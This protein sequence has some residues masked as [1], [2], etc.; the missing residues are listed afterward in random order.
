MRVPRLGDRLLPMRR[1]HLTHRRALIALIVLAALVAVASA[2][3]VLRV[4][5]ARAEA[6]AAMALLDRSRATLGPLL[7]FDTSTWPGREGYAQ[8]QD[9]LRAAE[10]HLRRTDERLGY[11]QWFDVLGRVVP[12]YGQSIRNGPAL[13]DLTITV[14]RE[15]GGV[16]AEAEPLFVGTGN[17]GDRARDVFVERHEALDGHLARLEAV[18]AESQRLAGVRWAGPMDRAAR[19]LPEL[20]AD[21]AR[22]TSV[23]STSARLAAGLEPL[24]GYGGPRSYIVL[25]QN[26]QEIRPTGGFLGTMGVVK[27]AEG[28]IEAFEYASSYEYDPKPP[29]FRVP[30]EDF[31]RG[32]GSRYWYVRDANWSPSFPEAAGAVQQ[33]LREDRGLEADGVIAVDTEMLRLLLEALGPMDVQGI[34]V[35]LTAENFYAALEEEIFGEETEIAAKKRTILGRVLQ[36]S[37]DRVQAADADKVPALVAVLRRGVGGR[38][39]QIFGND[40]RVEAMAEAFGADGTMRRRDGRDF[41]AVVDANVSYSKMGAAISRETTYLRRGD[42]R[43]DLFVSWRNDLTQFAGQRYKRLGQA[44]TLY[45]ATSGTYTKTKGV[46]A[47]VFRIYLPLGST[48]ESY[49]G[50]TPTFRLELGMLVLVGRVEVVDG[51]QRTIAITYRP[52]GTPTGVDVWKQGGQG[53]DRLRVLAANGRQQ[54]ALFDAAFA[55]DT[56]ANF[57]NAA[58]LT[59]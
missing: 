1:L 27:V 5:D 16:F 51:E 7:R 41:V 25:G 52:A 3:A 8:L 42:G 37:I 43:V 15:A 59:P 36:Q 33:F 9:D 53:R 22:V 55:Q 57:A 31:G 35:P 17:S 23:R 48:V 44:A 26:E 30:P 28:K 29:K 24:L 50:F 40:P 39:L 19:I 21:L 46:Y 20:D 2:D 13:L 58:T 6:K 18:R 54:D 56:G 4:R 10:G 34:D 12:R 45:D 38:H 47:N 49:E 32:L 14:T 11:L